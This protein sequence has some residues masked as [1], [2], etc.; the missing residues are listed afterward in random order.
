MQELKIGVPI[1]FASRI[2]KIAILGFIFTLGGISGT[3]RPFLTVADRS[4][5]LLQEP[6]PKE[7]QRAKYSSPK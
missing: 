2:G 7:S 1:K 5:T 3:L 6:S 4:V